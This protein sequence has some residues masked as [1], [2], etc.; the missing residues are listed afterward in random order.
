MC[1]G[2]GKL[3]RGQAE[4]GVRSISVASLLLIRG[5]PNI[6]G[7]GEGGVLPNILDL[8]KVLSILYSGPR[9]PQLF[10]ACGRQVCIAR[11]IARV[12][13]W[14]IIETRSLAF[15]NGK[16]VKIVLVLNMEEGKNS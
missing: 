16:Q 4:T 1:V 11:H 12:L 6:K 5:V 13:N 15:A 14:A 3:E 10:P 9:I 8:S 7:M 2:C